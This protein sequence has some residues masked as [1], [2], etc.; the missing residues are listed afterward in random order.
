MLNTTT[1][2]VSQVLLTWLMN[3][4]VYFHANEEERAGLGLQ[5]PQGIGYGIG[6]AFAVFANDDPVE[7][8][9]CAVTERGL[10]AAEDFGRS[11]VCVLLEGLADG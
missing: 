2:L 3:S 6:L 4:Y 5:K 10:G 7:V 8:P 9:R 1:P 11:H